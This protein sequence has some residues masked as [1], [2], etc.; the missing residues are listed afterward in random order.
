MGLLDVV[1]NVL[2]IYKA[3]ISDH[4]AKVKSLTGVQKELA[5]AEMG[6]AKARN[7]HIDEWT[8]GLKNI[9]I[10]IGA[11]AL[12]YSSLKEYGDR[13]D[14]EAAAGKVSI[15]QL[16]DAAMGLKTR[17]ELLGYA[18]IF[19]NSA[20]DL[21]QQQMN[22]VVR[23]MFNLEERGR[24]ANEVWSAMQA[25]LTKGTT[26]ALEGLIGPIDKTGLAF[27]AAGD[28]LT[29]Y[30]Q[31]GELVTR[32]MRELTKVNQE[33]GPAQLDA[34][35]QVEAGVVKLRDAWSDLK[36]SLGA[37]VSA[38][39]PLI[40]ALSTVLGLVSDVIDK[41]RQGKRA[42]ANNFQ[43]SPY[44]FLMA[45]TGMTPLINNVN[46]IKDWSGTVGT[47]DDQAGYGFDL[48]H[49]A[50]ASIRNRRA[51]AAATEIEKPAKNR[52]RKRG[53]GKE[54]LVNVQKLGLTKFKH[55]DF[56]HYG[57][58]DDYDHTLEG[59]LW[60][61]ELAERE[62]AKQRARQREV[63]TRESRYAAFNAKQGDSKLEKM[64]GKVSEFDAYKIAFDSLGGAV[65]SSLKAWVDG[66][67]SAGKAFKKFI[68]SAIES[69]GLQMVVE[70]LKEA[71]YAIGSLA[72]GDA[73][74]AALRGKAAAAHAAGAAVALGIA[75]TM[76]GSSASAPGG[77]G[78]P[79]GG[80]N[81]TGTNAYQRPNA[82][83]VIVYGDPFA[84]DSPRN[85]QVQA[86]RIVNLALG[87]GNGVRAA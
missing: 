74:G 13:L 49:W 54:D 29:N 64:F 14:L 53:E 78:S 47:F 77:A 70:S 28:K 24:D 85:R 20:F 7:K 3:D 59:E 66:S 17:M 10:A 55:S 67:E 68:G 75:K 86:Q 80:W 83:A 42:D 62:E 82:G 32:V 51:I 61:A 18:A 23:A 22:T 33:A 38:F 46:D 65:Q 44:D 73:P 4:A 6:A 43:N 11:V 35:D 30:Q 76:N 5:E 52:G 87:G 45:A 36:T 19:N 2:T 34:A 8:E 60:N 72:M 63:S 21:T 39:A 27:D 15:D 81:G 41:T 16:S 9:G 31:K 56:V 25:L 37:L 50:L 48:R 84:M 26:K 40:K 12:A 1:S 69:V 58:F 57:D 71:A 79:G